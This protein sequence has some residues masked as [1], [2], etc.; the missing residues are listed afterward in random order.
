[1]FVFPDEIWRKYRKELGIQKT[2][3]Y[4]TAK[5]LPARWPEEI[6]NPEEWGTLFIPG[7]KPYNKSDCKNYA[8]YYLRGGISGVKCDGVDEL[9]PGIVWYHVCRNDFK[10]CPFYKE[11]KNE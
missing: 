6:P 11:E 1:M 8:G 5:G 4:L 10:K 3:D 2:V 7:G 9:L